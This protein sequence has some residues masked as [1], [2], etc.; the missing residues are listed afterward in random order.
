MPWK[1]SLDHVIDP[2]LLTASVHYLKR[3]DKMKKEKKNRKTDIS[4]NQSSGCSKK[5]QF[6]GEK[7]EQRFFKIYGLLSSSRSNTVMHC[8]GRSTL[9]ICDFGSNIVVGVDVKC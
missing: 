1:F 3:F 5:K 7:M 2:N 8:S 4:L 6:V 9:A